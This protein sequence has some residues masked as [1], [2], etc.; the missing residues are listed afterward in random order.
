[1]RFSIH[2]GTAELS[3]YSDNGAASTEHVRRGQLANNLL[4]RSQQ[5]DC[6]VHLPHEAYTPNSI[7][8]QI[9]R[10][11]DVEFHVSDGRQGHR[12]GK[13]VVERDAQVGVE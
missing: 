1:M 2:I 7:Q 11:I 3:P 8:P 13:S 12:G 5:I 10:L 4:N 6:R 9:R